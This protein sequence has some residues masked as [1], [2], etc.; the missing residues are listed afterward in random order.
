[1]Y[2]LPTSPK[3]CASTVGK[4]DVGTFIRTVYLE[5]NLTHSAFLECSEPLY[6]RQKMPE[7]RRRNQGA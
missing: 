6:M 2:E 3:I 5:T 1:M 4:F 7:I